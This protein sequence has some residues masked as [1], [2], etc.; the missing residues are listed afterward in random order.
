MSGMSGYMLLPGDVGSDRVRG[1]V[2]QPQVNERVTVSPY[3][4]TL[5]QDMVLYVTQIE[6]EML[7]TDLGPGPPGLDCG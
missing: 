3:H 7:R 1:P 6:L 4:S 5:G 2:C